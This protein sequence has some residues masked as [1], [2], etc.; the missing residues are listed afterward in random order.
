MS[1]RRA[2]LRSLNVP[3]E[4]ARARALE[5]DWDRVCRQFVAYLEPIRRWKPDPGMPA[6]A[7]WA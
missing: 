4:R 2:A 7:H 6:I 5:F 1:S 3:R